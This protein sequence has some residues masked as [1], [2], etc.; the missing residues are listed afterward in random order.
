MD[1]VLRHDEC[2]VLDGRARNVVELDVTG[3][4]GRI[5]GLSLRLFDVKRQR[6]TLNFSNTASGTLTPPMTGGFGGSRRGVFY[7]A[8]SLRGKPILVQFVIDVL[9]A[10]QDLGSE[11]GC[12]GYASALIKPSTQFR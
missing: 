12:G 9:D 5:E 6:W 8:E 11:L 10:R 3:P 2:P 7:S 1:R 4:L